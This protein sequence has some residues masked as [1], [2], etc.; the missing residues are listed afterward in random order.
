[1]WLL[2]ADA[3]DV[4]SCDSLLDQYNSLYERNKK[5]HEN[6]QQ[7]SDV[8]VELRAERE[9]EGGARSCGGVAK[10]ELVNNVPHCDV[11]DS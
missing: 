1:M 4:V 7:C 10:R 2:V 3:G 5:L 9:E 6:V 11:S 8:V